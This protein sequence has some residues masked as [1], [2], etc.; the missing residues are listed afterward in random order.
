MSVLLFS[1]FSILSTITTVL[2]KYIHWQA[3]ML[4]TMLWFYIKVFIRL[5]FK[6]I[7]KFEV[8][9]IKKTKYGRQRGRVIQ[10]MSQMMKVS[11]ILPCRAISWFTQL[12]W[13]H[14]LM[15]MNCLFFFYCYLTFCVLEEYVPKLTMCAIVNKQSLICF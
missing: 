5:K 3:T 12:S 1:F 13:L 15:T 6:Y 7:F 9:L 8:N 10:I 4:G 2:S 14:P 11:T